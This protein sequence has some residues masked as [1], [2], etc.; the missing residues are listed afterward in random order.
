MQTASLSSDL[1]THRFKPLSV[2]VEQEPGG[3]CLPTF[4]GTS[5]PDSG[6]GPSSASQ[7]DVLVVRL[8]LGCEERVARLFSLAFVGAVEVTAS[9]ESVGRGQRTVAGGVECI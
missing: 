6:E 8:A 4:L 9:A 7:G 3:D 5:Q 1:A 2:G